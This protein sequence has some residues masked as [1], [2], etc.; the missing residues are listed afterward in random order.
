MAT[1]FEIAIAI[2][3]IDGY[4]I[5]CACFTGV[6]LQYILPYKIFYD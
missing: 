4:D 2:A 3:V 6:H 5:V 1:I